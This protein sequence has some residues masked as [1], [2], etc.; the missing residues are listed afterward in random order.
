M[1]KCNFKQFACPGCMTHCSFVESAGRVRSQVRF[2]PL[3]CYD[4]LNLLLM[5]TPGRDRRNSFRPPPRQPRRV[6]VRFMNCSP[7]QLSPQSVGLT[8]RPA[9]GLSWGP[10]AQCSRRFQFFWHSFFSVVF[11]LLSFRWLAAAAVMFR[12][13]MSSCGDVT[14][15]YAKAKHTPLAACVRRRVLAVDRF[16]LTIGVTGWYEMSVVVAV[17]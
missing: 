16:Y 7:R 8:D 13:I 12:V 2:R 4:L 3:E 14:G 9:H 10:V 11:S 15:K 1:L 17:G 5:K 6:G